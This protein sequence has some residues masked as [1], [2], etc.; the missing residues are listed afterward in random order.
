MIGSP[1]RS[2]DRLDQSEA[3][4]ARH[5][6]VGDHEVGVPRREDLQALLPVG[7]RDRFVAV[8]RKLGGEAL[9]ERGVVVH[10][11]KERS[12]ACHGVA[13]TAGP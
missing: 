1:V 10:D 2:A 8:R 12:G 13:T 7:G 9:R 5:R 6:V 4:Q 3:V 11:E